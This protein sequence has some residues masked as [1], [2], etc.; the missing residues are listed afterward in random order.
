MLDLLLEGGTVLD[1]AGTAPRTA[2]VGVRDGRIVEVGR[3]TEA[4]RER[5]RAS[6]AWVTPG[7]IDIHTRRKSIDQAAPSEP[8][9]SGRGTS[10]DEAV[11]TSTPTT[12]KTRA[13]VLQK[14]MR[15]RFQSASTKGGFSPPKTT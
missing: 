2:D 10:I 3:I 1:G 9:P 14:R 4:T 5:V 7:F 15:S 8:P 6:G 12:A 11:S 13:A